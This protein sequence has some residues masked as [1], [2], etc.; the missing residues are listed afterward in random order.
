MK[1]IARFGCEDWEEFLELI[2]SADLIYTNKKGEDRIIYI[3]PDYMGYMLYD[4]ETEEDLHFK[5]PEELLKGYTFS[6][7]VSLMDVYNGENWTDD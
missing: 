7:G 4:Y 5:T 6:D 1:R 2:Q 3:E